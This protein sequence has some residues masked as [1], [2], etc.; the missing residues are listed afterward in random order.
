MKKRR[1]NDMVPEESDQNKCG[2]IKT[3]R[4]SQIMMVRQKKLDK[5][6][7]DIGPAPG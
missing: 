2:G 4:E 5:I 7:F 6:N 1:T 3:L